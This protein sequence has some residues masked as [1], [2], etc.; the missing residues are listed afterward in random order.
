[1]ASE[2]LRFDLM[3]SSKDLKKLMLDRI[4]ELKV[5]PYNL[6]M[7]LGIPF[8]YWSE[9]V[10]MFDTTRVLNMSKRLSQMDIKKIAERIGIYPSLIIRVKDIEEVDVSSLQNYKKSYV[11]TI[12]KKNIKEYDEYCDNLEKT[13]SEE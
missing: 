10:K 5:H 7:E 2:G 3:F 13:L 6:C 11:P 9:Y 1:M 8:K 12:S 4:K